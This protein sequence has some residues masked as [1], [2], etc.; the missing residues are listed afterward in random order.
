MAQVPWQTPL[1]EYAFI[2]GFYLPSR[3][4]LVY[5]Y[6]EGDLTYGMFNLKSINFN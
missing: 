2:D 4:E 1:K 6:P 3:A 5:N